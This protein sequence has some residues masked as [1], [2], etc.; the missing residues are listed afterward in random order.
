MCQPVSIPK[1]KCCHVDEIFIKCCIGS[2]NFSA[3][4]EII[5]VKMMIFLF[6]WKCPFQQSCAIVYIPWSMNTTLFC[7]PLLCVCYQHLAYHLLLPASFVWRMYQWSSLTTNFFIFT[8]GVHITGIWNESVYNET[9][10]IRDLVSMDH[11][12]LNM[13]RVKDGVKSQA[14]SHSWNP[15]ASAMNL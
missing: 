1:V 6:Q 2:C 4:S 15:V 9:D 5:L 8:M 10:I 12:R 7:L 3:A 13:G 11:F 14:I